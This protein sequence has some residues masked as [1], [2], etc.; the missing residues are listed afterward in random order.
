MKLAVAFLLLAACGNDSMSVS[1]DGGGGGGGSGSGSGGGGGGSITTIN[2]SP[3]GDATW[4]GQIRI[5]ASIDIP[6]GV[7]ITVAAG[8]TVEV[9]S[10]ASITVDGALAI[11]GVKG[12]TVTIE[13]LAS[14]TWGFLTVHTGGSVTMS[15]AE[16]TGGNIDVQSNGSIM[17]R[18]S[19]LSR[20][21]GDLL[22]SEGGNIDVAY[23]WLG[24]PQ[25]QSDTTH[26]DMHFEDGSPTLSIT[27]TNISTSVYG[28]M[29]Y[30]GTNADFTSN[31]WFS[32]SIQVDPTAA[33][34]G[35]F[36][37]GYFDKNP[38][39]GT[40]ITASNLASAMLT[41]AGPR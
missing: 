29:F 24:E 4:S 1:A 34:T 10:S 6:N 2:G 35:D 33:V 26:C 30:A 13:G 32:N 9:A 20:V 38:P 16:Y 40:G 39:S 19:E 7:T 21:V 41:D 12:S 22:T 8:S 31:N 3:T 18:D 36:S 15:Y 14:D 23:T 25:G 28:V 37:N 5:T 17:L 27:H 11:A